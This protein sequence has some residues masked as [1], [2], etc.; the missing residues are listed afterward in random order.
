MPGSR[1][2]LLAESNDER[3]IK[4][5]NQLIRRVDHTKSRGLINDNRLSWSYFVFPF[6][7]GMGM[8]A[9]FFFSARIFLIVFFLFFVFGYIAWG[10]GRERGTL[11]LKAWRSLSIRPTCL[12][13]EDHFNTRILGMSGI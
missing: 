1:Q 3:K 4:L 12:A 7:R 13:I 2:K 10:R 9:H 8:F 6:L 11:R 5:E